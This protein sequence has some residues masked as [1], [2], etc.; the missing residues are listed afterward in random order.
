M[1]FIVSVKSELESSPPND[2]TERDFNESVM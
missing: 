2:P 1:I